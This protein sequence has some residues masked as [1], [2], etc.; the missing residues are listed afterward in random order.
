MMFIKIAATILSL[1]VY[2]TGELCVDSILKIKADSGEKAS[3]S[4]LIDDD[5]LDCLQPHIKSHCKKS[6]GASFCCEDSTAKFGVFIPELNK[7]KYKYCAWRP[8]LR[9]CDIKSVAESCPVMCGTCHPTSE[10]LQII[11]DE[12]TIT[13]E[14]INDLKSKVMEQTATIENQENAIEDQLEKINDIKNNVTEQDTKIK[15]QKERI[16]VLEANVGVYAFGDYLYK[17]GYKMMTWE[18]HEAA[19]VAWGGHLSSV[20]SAE[21]N[22]FITS[23]FDEVWFFIGLKLNAQN[24]FEEFTDG[25]SVAYSKWYPGQPENKGEDAVAIW[26]GEW[27]DATGGNEA[28]GVY[29]KL[30]PYV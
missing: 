12:K 6:C 23:L 27:H 20:H 26:L 11:A 13:T 8:I 21:E 10:I 30:N 4:E 15:E 18:D 14:E 7:T 22:A 1:G 16:N 19:A 5:A 25:S 9:Q 2:A 28:A 24:I 3:C 29:K 17:V